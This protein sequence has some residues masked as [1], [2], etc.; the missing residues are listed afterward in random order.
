MQRVALL[1][2]LLLSLAGLLFAQDAAPE[3]QG[4]PNQPSGL[5]GPAQAPR[6]P[7][8]PEPR[9]GSGVAPATTQIP[10]L[11][12]P[13]RS[14]AWRAVSPVGGAGA[15]P[16]PEFSLAGR[17]LSAT[18]EPVGLLRIDNALHLVRVSD[19]LILRLDAASDPTRGGAPRNGQ[20]QALGPRAPFLLTLKV[21]RLD[22]QGLVLQLSELDRTLTLR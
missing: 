4:A 22:A 7:A 21:T 3:R 8:T 20:K 18:A 12:D 9:R 11:R 5:P 1:T 14:P 10:L 6:A 13:T 19:T 16:L 15:H 2:L 17:I